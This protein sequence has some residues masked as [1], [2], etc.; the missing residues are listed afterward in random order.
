MVLLPIKILQTLNTLK[1]ILLLLKPLQTLTIRLVV[2]VFLLIA[3]S[4]EVPVCE[5]RGVSTLNTG[6][7]TRS[8]NAIGEVTNTPLQVRLLE[9][10]IPEQA[11]F[12]TPVVATQFRLPLPVLED[13]VTYVFTRDSIDAARPTRTDTIQFAFERNLVIPSFHCDPEIR[14]DSIRVVSSTLSPE[15]IVVM[16]PQSFLTND[17]N[18]QI[19]Y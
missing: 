6:F 15:N 16:R 9:L 11:I 8:V 17:L 5:E 19:F 12:V 10:Y 4:C 1:S 3:S 7:F 18:I 2:P 14:Y 13:Q